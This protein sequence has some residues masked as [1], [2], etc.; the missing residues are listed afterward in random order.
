MSET[1]EEEIYPIQEQDLRLLKTIC[2][3]PRLGLDFAAT[4]SSD[5]FCGDTKEVAKAILDYIKTYKSSPT[6]R[7]LVDA[8]HKNYDLVSKIEEVFDQFDSIDFNIVEYQYDIDKL[9]QRYVDIKIADLRD[10]FRYGDT[11]DVEATVRMVERTLKDVAEVRSPAKKAFTQKSLKQHLPDFK[12]EYVARLSDPTLGKGIQTGYSYLD[13]ITNGLRPAELLI[14]GAVTSAG[15]SML[16]NNMAIQMWMQKNAITTQE[17]DFTQGYNVLYFSLEMPY[18]GCFRRTMARVADVP[19][20]G[21]RD[22]TLSRSEADSVSTASRFINKY[23]F[24]FEIV[25]IPRGVTVERIEERY[26]E[27]KSR[28]EPHIIV[29]D[30]L[31]LLSDPDAE[32]DDWLKLGHIAGKLHEFA[33]VHDVRV[34]T[35]VQL[36]RATLKKDQDPGELI[37]VHRFGRS[38]LIAHHAN[39]CIQIE[40]RPDEHLRGDFVYHVIK[41]RDG[42]RGNHAITKKFSHCAIY[43]TPYTPLDRDEFGALV[44]GFDDSQDISDQVARILGI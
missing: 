5:L 14:I 17:Q 22:S 34:L 27:A 18:E 2:N 10:G 32:G 36:N 33:R 39:I 31:G 9:R 19:S 4:Y 7:V 3:D 1:M 13:Y 6:K 26:L 28:F 12:Q 16:L 24:E 25:D 40:D 8:H 15:K 20:Y 41:N 30:Y 42:E 23:P 43:D 44:A 35:A 37:G 38:S 11:N 21:L 29:V